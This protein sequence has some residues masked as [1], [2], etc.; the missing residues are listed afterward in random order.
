MLAP[1][2]D[3]LRAVDISAV[4]IERAR[5]RCAQI[6]NIE[7]GT[8]DFFREPIEGLWG[9]IGCTEVLYYAGDAEPVRKLAGHFRDQ[10]DPGGPL[11]T[12][13][14]PPLSDNPGSHLFHWVSP[15]GHPPTL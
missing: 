5:Q 11:V 7:F 13:P 10:P 9:L 4:A 14:A 8:Q 15:S 3:V 1:R 2:A 12:D 6:P